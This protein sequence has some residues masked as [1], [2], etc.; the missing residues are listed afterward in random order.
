M[1]EAYLKFKRYVEDINL[2]TSSM[3]SLNFCRKQ[4]LISEQTY[5]Y[6]LWALTEYLNILRE[7]IEKD[8][9]EIA[10]KYKK[11]LEGG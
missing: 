4:K 9:N 1:S 11:K 5:S 10:Q 3:N 7:Q 6:L 2:Y 8:F